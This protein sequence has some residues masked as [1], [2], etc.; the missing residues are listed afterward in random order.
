MD[1]FD[2]VDQWLETL[3]G[4][5]DLEGLET[6]DWPDLLDTVRATSRRV[7]HAA[8]PVTSFAVGYAA[9]KSDGS[10]KTIAA[11]FADVRAALPVKEAE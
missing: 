11:L 9:A 5:L 10:A 2:V 4:H 1:E 6:P 3:R 8:G 7:I